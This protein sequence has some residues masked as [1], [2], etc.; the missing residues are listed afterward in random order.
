MNH[1]TERGFLGALFDFSFTTFITTKIIK[2]VYGVAIF[3]C[4]LGALAFLIGG[5]SRSFLAGIGALILSP[6]IFILY[7]MLTRIWLELII[8]IFRIAEH[9]AAIESHIKERG[10]SDNQS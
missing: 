10:N 1:R 9:T 5:F 4:G 7:V 3:L 2:V 6:I 8:V